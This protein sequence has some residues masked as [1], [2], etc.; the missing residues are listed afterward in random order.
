MTAFH[1]QQ[2]PQAAN[3]GGAAEHQPRKAGG[4]LRDFA[5]AAC[6]AA[7]RREAQTRS[8][9]CGAVSG[10]EGGATAEGAAL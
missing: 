5:A 8:A 4:L 9:V 7:R 10:R 1:V 3:K 6:S 2:W